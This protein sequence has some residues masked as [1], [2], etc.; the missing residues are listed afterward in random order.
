MNKERRSFSAAMDAPGAL[1]KNSVVII[2]GYEKSTF[3]VIFKELEQH[4]P[5]SE[6]VAQKK[7]I[8]TSFVSS[9][10]LARVEKLVC[11]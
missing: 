6:K 10:I 4:L 2:A 8:I 9:T 11:F 5:Q 7:F 1:W 3:Q